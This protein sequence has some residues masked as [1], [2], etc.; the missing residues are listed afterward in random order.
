MRT[1]K[2]LWGSHCQLLPEQAAELK[3]EF[4]DDVIVVSLARAE[5]I[6]DIASILPDSCNMHDLANM[7]F[8][9]L[10]ENGYDAVVLSDGP[11]AFQFVLGKAARGYRVC[12]LYVCPAQADGTANFVWVYGPYI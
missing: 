8:R 7:F 4:G 1:K 10:E 6:P 11:S 9:A 3:T 5:D 2:V 12:V